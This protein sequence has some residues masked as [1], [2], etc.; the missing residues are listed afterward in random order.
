MTEKEREK[1]IAE[2]EEEIDSIATQDEVIEFEE[3]RKQ[4]RQNV[5]LWVLGGFATFLSFFLIMLVA[6]GLDKIIY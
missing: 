1:R 5:L 3:D 2:L 6:F 4:A